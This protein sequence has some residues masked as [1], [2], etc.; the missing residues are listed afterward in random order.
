MEGLIIISFISIIT[1]IGLF[2]LTVDLF[3]T[4]D[5]EETLMNHYETNKNYYE[6]VDSDYE[7][8]DYLRE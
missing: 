5:T 4:E 1:I 2:S 7:Y 6:L 3:Y 8:N